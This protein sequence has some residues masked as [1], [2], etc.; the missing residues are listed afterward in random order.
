MN[1]ANLFSSKKFTL[2]NLA[3]NIDVFTFENC[4]IKLAYAQEKK[5]F[6][7]S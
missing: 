7:L 1:K 6:L 4:C 2:K 3:M 5:N